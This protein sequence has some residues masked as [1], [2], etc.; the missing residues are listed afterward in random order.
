M[1]SCRFKIRFSED[2]GHADRMEI[3]TELM[4][5]PKKSGND[6]SNLYWYRM[7][8]NGIATFWSATPAMTE[9][10][11]TW[12]SDKVTEGKLEKLRP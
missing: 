4:R 8:H 11:E 5:L 9:T 10:I 1:Y 3:M 6:P 2:V 7:K 12:I